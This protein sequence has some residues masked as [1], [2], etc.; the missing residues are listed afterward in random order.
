MSKSN[1]QL[2]IADYVS[3]GRALLAFPLALVFSNPNHATLVIILMLIIILSD[4]LDGIIAR[5]IN[6]ESPY[7]KTLDPCAD[8]FVNIVVLVNLFSLG[9]ISLAL[10]I[11]YVVRVIHIV[12][13]MWQFY[14]KTLNTPILSP[15]AVNTGKASHVIIFAYFFYSFFF[16]FN[17]FFELACFTIMMYSMLRYQQPYKEIKNHNAKTT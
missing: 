6:H 17:L 3:L 13:N 16:G 2:S 10:L 5:H 8:A 9:K 1:N 4:F 14:H 7:G 12:R 15:S 11:L